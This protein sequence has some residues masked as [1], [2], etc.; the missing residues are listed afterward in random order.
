MNFAFSRTSNL[1]HFVGAN[2]CPHII[3]F[4]SLRSTPLYAKF[5]RTSQTRLFALFGVLIPFSLFCF[6]IQRGGDCLAAPRVR[7]LP[8]RL[9]CPADRLAIS[10]TASA[11][12]RLALEPPRQGYSPCSGFSSRF[13]Y[14]VFKFREEGIRTPGEVTLTQPFQDCTLSHSDT[15][16]S[17]CIITETHKI[18]KCQTP[19]FMLTYTYDFTC[20]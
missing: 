8:R 19:K 13:L 10:P 18:V 4:R 6:Q 3:E 9:I 16:L 15:S 14:S 2:F 5:T 12:A 11:F 7:R 17:V 20:E 1:L